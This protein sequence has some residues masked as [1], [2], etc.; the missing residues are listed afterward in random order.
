MGADPKVLEELR[1]ET[2]T[3][4]VQDKQQTHIGDFETLGFG[5]NYRFKRKVT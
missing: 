1:Y 2:P 4:E 5:T 3:G